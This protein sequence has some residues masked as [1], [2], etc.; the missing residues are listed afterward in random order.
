MTV[1]ANSCAIPG[2]YTIFV[3]AQIGASASS[4]PYTITV[5]PSV[6]DVTASAQNLNL[7]NLAGQPS[8]PIDLIVNITS[9]VTI[10][11]ANSTLT[12]L[13]T[14]GFLSGTNLTINND[15][16]IVGAGGAGGTIVGSNQS[17]CPDANGKPGGTALE[18]LVTNVIINNNGTIGGG[19]GGG[20]AGEDLTGANPCIQYYPG[21]PGGGGAGSIPGVGGA[22]DNACTVAGK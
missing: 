5:A 14:G 18:L 9:G 10:G 20:G 17:N 2:I 16:S 8:C 19:G 7:Y 11:S 6:I 13:T 22:P 1:T 4:I 3:T 12:A 15:G 21:T